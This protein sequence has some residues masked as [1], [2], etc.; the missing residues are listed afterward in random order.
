LIKGKNIKNKRIKEEANE[1]VKQ[2]FKEEK[3]ELDIYNLE[4]F[5]KVVTRNIDFS[6]TKTFQ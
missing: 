6:N 2:Y 3:Q 4:N 5:E 1:G